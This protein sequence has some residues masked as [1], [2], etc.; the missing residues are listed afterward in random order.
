MD[1]NIE[2]LNV[3][4]VEDSPT[5]AIM[6]KEILE[7]NRLH[8]KLA[9]DG[10]EG[11]QLLSEGIPNIII[12]DIEMP[13]MNGY[14]FCKHVKTDTLY[15]EI[16]VIL[17][18]NLT[19]VLDVVKGIE[20]GADSFLTKPCETTLLLTT[21]KNAIQNKDVQNN[22]SNGKLEFYFDGRNHALEVDQ[23]QITKLLLS[24][25]SNA[26]QKNLELEEAYRKLN[27]IHEELEKTNRTLKLLNE[28][29][30]QFLGMAAHDLR[31]P[32]TVISGF[33]SYL[34]NVR[35]ENFDE[36]KLPQMIGH[37]HNSSNFML[38]LIDDLLDYSVIES[39]TLSL[40]LADT[41]LTDLIQKNMIFFESLAQKKNIKVVFNPVSVPKVSCDANKVLQVIN[42]L[43]TNAN[44]FSHPQGTITITLT[45]L[46]TEVVIS[47]EDSGIGMSEEALKNLFQPFNKSKTLGT[48]GEKGSGLGLA[49]VHKIINEHHGKI[50][51]DSE[52]NKGTTFFVSLP[53]TQPSLASPVPVS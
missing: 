12:S 5:Q 39:G 32:L 11:L 13:R 24:T 51:V 45:P 21:I 7:K 14:D 16:P 38:R 2:N 20:C 15:K 43:F 33:S 23:V 1:T 6:L 18:T 34:L 9:K 10:V 25:Y 53:Y 19:D 29:K 41:D 26:I 8:V 44:K 52:L 46:E 42:N 28:Q 47:V 27:K 22:I 4:Y 49:I 35:K 36:T 50:W 17:L 3:L 31:N 30:N 48:A 40:N 37:I